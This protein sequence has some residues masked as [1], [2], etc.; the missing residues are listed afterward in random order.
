MAKKRIMSDYSYLSKFYDPFTG[1]VDY[2]RRA[3]FIEGG[4]V[5]NRHIPVFVGL[6]RAAPLKIE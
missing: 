5:E 3:D 6:Y 1:N 4:I 2:N